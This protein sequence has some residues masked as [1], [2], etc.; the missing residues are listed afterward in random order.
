MTYGTA[1]GLSF[2]FST[3]ANNPTA[4]V[5][6]SGLSSS[7]Q[8]FTAGSTTY[9]PTG[10][11]GLS[12]YITISTPLTSTLA[13]SGGSYSLTLTPTTLA[14]T[15]LTFQAG[16]ATSITI[17]KANLTATG[18]KV[19]NGAT[20]FSGSSL[21]IAGVNSETFTATGSGTLS[22]TNVQTN[23]A[24]SS[25]GTLSL[26]GVGG[27]STGNY[28]TLTTSQTSVSVTAAPITISTSNVTKNYN[29]SLTAVGTATVTSGTLYTN[30]SN[31][32]TLDSL[33]GGSFAFTNA[34]YGSGNKTVTVSGVTVNDG[35]SG[36]NYSVT[37]ASNTTSTINAA[38]ITISTSNVSKTYDGALTATG[39]ATVTSGTLYTN[40]SNSN[41]LDSISGGSFA[42]ADKNVGSG[43]KTVTVSSVTVTDGNSGNNYS[44]TYA[45]NTTSTITQL[46]TINYT[47]ASGG[48]W[49]TA[50]NW[51][52]SKIPDLSNVATA[53]IPVNTV[54]VYDYDHS[55]NNYSNSAI[56]VNSGSKV[57]FNNASSITASNN[58]SG[59]GGIEKLA[60]SMLT[61]SG[62]NTYTGATT[63]TA[64]T[65]KLGSSTALSSS[66]A[67][68]VSSGT[69]LD[70]N[71]Y[72]GTL[73]SITGSG[74]IYNS[75]QSTTSTLTSGA[76]NTSTTFDGI[77]K[78][79]TGT[80]GIVAV[81]KSG[82]GT[83]TLSGTNT[84]S[85][86]TIVRAGNI[87]ADNS[88][89]F[90]SG[91][92]TLGNTTGTSAA[93]IYGDA[94]GS[95][96]ITNA[97]I[98]ATNSNNPT[99]TIGN[100]SA[101][102][103]GTTTF[104][105]GITGANNFI[106]ANNGA[107]ALLFSGSAINNTGSITN[108]G[109][110]A[111]RTT[112]NARIGDPTFGNV[113]VTNVVQNGTSP[114]YL[115]F[116]GNVWNG[117]TTITSGKIVTTAN[118]SISDP[119]EYN[120]VIVND[121]LDLLGTSQRIGDLSGSGTITTTTSGASP[122][123]T[124]TQ[125]GNT[126]FSGI[127]ENG[128]GIV[129]FTKDGTGTLTLS[130][131]NSTYTGVTTIMG[132]GTL[133]V[134]KISNSATAG[135]I[136]S[137]S[138]IVLD[139]GTLKFT[140]AQDSTNRSITKTSNEGI[141]DGSG[142]GGLIINGN[143]T[144]NAGITTT[145]TLTG[146]NADNAIRG[147]IYNPTSSGSLSI[148]KSGSGTWALSGVN[149]YTGATTINAGTI[150]VSANNNLGTV[151]AYYPGNIIFNG[152]TL[153]TTATFTLSGRGIY[154]D[155]NATINTD[156][157]TILT[158]PMNITARSGS[159]TFTKSGAGI[160]VLSGSN[161]RWY[162]GTNINA[163]TIRLAANN[164]LPNIGTVTLTNA[165]GALL[166]LDGYN[167]TVGS[168][169]GGGSTGG[170]ISLGTGNLTSAATTN[171][172]YD[173]IISGTGSFTLNGNS[174]LTLTRA[175]TYTGGTN[176]TLGRIHV[177]V[178]NALPSGYNL[179]FTGSGGDLYFDGAV[180]QTIGI[181]TAASSGPDIDI[182]NATL[183][184]TQNA[185]STFVRNIKGSGTITKNGT[186]KLTLAGSNTY[187]G[188]TTI[189]AG[190]IIAGASANI[191]GTG[192]VTF[193]DVE[194]AK[195]ELNNYNVTVGSISGGG[196]TGGNIILGSGNITTAPLTNTT[197]S[198]V[199][200]GSGSLTLNGRAGLTLANSNV[201]TGGTNI[202]S[203]RFQIGADNAIASG[204]ALT[205]TGSGGDM[206]FL[207]GNIQQTIGSFISLNSSPRVDLSSARL[208]INSSS[209][210]TFNATIV[211]VNGSGRLIKQGTGRLSFRNA[212]ISNPALL[213]DDSN[214]L[215]YI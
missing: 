126:T 139:G 111:G 140:G 180:T 134:S 191:L 92:I 203:G 118:Y 129:S 215:D 76:N 20:S 181:F 157:S 13:V 212:G 62:T 87:Y 86:G 91:S 187:A 42:F 207:A 171:T 211:G 179:T 97:I 12:G 202:T 125:T 41:T 72:S 25:V 163:G 21:T 53:V 198:G 77:I 8:T 127:I 82:T 78:D 176:I 90:G 104:T 186:G 162:A 95:L 24:L 43:N 5:G 98:L 123:L 89:V 165:S 59:A 54:V 2:Y 85:G 88:S 32:N 17:N 75:A 149:T 74:T 124:V 151:P 199:I 79:N 175:N 137:G 65:L 96:T 73:G 51:Q 128:A 28:N 153:N 160:L 209:T 144:P 185:D 14:K 214:S 190:S 30:A 178:N 61:L 10:I 170:N 158:V 168:I 152:G 208:T 146:T 132:G 80:G 33:S 155:G 210:E 159:A 167:L 7:I 9:T 121:T 166:D 145:L 69:Y 3:S 112:I 52:D 173:G 70:L 56:T 122:N 63:I 48:N 64:G 66:S 193:A 189:N 36:N 206:F 93:G 99:I 57:Q 35:N 205:F 172:T 105:G 40:A 136:G 26:T 148:I 201:Y 81:V 142:S 67:A 120:A 15:G 106:I 177:G 103:S 138:S 184:I 71:S 55:G 150:K 117:T 107:G 196:S 44:V 11:S 23:Q 27:A 108:S 114:L 169:S 45:S 47:G 197:Y 133:V 119:S 1:Y 68:T 49:S 116:Q 50:S 110:G 109:S 34:N 100:T 113:N 84:Y 6:S 164:T 4:G 194:N 200:S 147:I 94:T 102:S 174:S 130:G 83:L 101:V 204:S 131:V 183:I 156:T 154:L 195:L 182:G 60:A 192:T 38:A 16:N 213:Q 37:Y 46:S 19:Y 135:S 161:N 22:S 115:G 39:T 143:I 141:I 188:G 18:T 31:A 58:I 29:G